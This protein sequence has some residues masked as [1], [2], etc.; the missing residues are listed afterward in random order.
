[1]APIAGARPPPLKR[2]Q[3]FILPETLKEDQIYPDLGPIGHKTAPGLNL[4]DHTWVQLLETPSEFDPIGYLMGNVLEFFLGE[5][6]LY[7]RTPIFIDK[8]FGSIF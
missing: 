5:S 6:K 4:N 3:T 2:A 8:L 7:L 1:M